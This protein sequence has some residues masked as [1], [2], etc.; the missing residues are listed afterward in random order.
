MTYSLSSEDLRDLNIGLIGYHEYPNLRKYKYFKDADL[1][2]SV[3]CY[4]CKL[5]VVGS[6][7]TISTN[8]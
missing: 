4:P 2:Q 6:S 8:I 1:T 3:E 7:P 5:E